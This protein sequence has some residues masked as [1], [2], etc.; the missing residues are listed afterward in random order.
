[1]GTP[2]LALLV[3][4][5]GGLV[6]GPQRPR[7]APW[8]RPA[9]RDSRTLTPTCRFTVSNNLLAQLILVPLPEKS[10]QGITRDTD[11]GHCEGPATGVWTRSQKQSC[12]IARARSQAGLPSKGPRRLTSSPVGALSPRE[13]RGETRSGDLALRPVPCGRSPFSAQKGQRP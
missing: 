8:R 6:V 3:R 9:P 7:E 10:S 13:G 5:E 12:R 2:G 1:M 4:N 11:W